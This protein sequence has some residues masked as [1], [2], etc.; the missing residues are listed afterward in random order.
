[1]YNFSLISLPSRPPKD[2][3]AEA[4]KSDALEVFSMIF[5]TVHRCDFSG[6]IVGC[7]W[8]LVNG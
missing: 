3:L 2:D 1:M 6:S 7:P 8:Y 5:P 4:E